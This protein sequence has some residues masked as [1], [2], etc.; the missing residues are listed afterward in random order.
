MLVPLCDQTVFE[1]YL[2]FNKENL[3]KWKSLLSAFFWLFYT[4]V[5]CG[6]CLKDALVLLL[7]SKV[8]CVAEAG[9][10][11]WFIFQLSCVKRWVSAVM[12]IYTCI[13]FCS[14]SRYY[15]R[16]LGNRRNGVWRFPRDSTS[17]K[18]QGPLFRDSPGR[19]QGE[20][21]NNRCSLKQHPK[22][23][24]V[25]KPWQRFSAFVSTLIFKFGR[26]TQFSNWPELGATL[27]YPKLKH[28]VFLNL[29]F[30]GEIILQRFVQH[31]LNLFTPLQLQSSQ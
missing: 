11:T 4:S 27:D 28:F 13:A 24:V 22:V 3:A 25:F 17:S 2:V 19:F 6:T 16:Q 10:G 1:S 12:S 15:R 31:R 20:T 9:V 14:I 7:I 30:R 21:Q 23:F 18:W 5:F 29:L 26:I 8:F